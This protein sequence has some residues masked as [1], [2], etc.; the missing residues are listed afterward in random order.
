MRQSLGTAVLFGMI[1]VTCFGLLFTPAFYTFIRKLGRKEHTGGG[2]PDLSPYSAS[3]DDREQ[4]AEFARP[5]V[6][7]LRIEH[8]FAGG[9][10]GVKDYAPPWRAPGRARFSSR[11]PIRPAMRR[12]I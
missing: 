1:G 11:S 5:S 12:S 9:Y 4:G 10:T 3:R 8:G 6:P 7:R 2:F